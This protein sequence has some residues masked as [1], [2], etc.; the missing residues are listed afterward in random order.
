MY[1]SNSTKSGLS[2]ILSTIAGHCMMWVAF[3]FRMAARVA[4]RDGPSGHTIP[5]LPAIAVN[6]T[7]H[8]PPTQKKGR[9]ATSRSPGWYELRAE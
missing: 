7:V 3:H 9:T 8:S 2:I 4:S 1:F 6:I 5:A